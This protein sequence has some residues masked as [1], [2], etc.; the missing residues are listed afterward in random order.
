MLNIGYIS[1]HITMA[2]TVKWRSMITV[3]NSIGNLLST[4]NQLLTTL[5]ARSTQNLRNSNLLQFD[6]F[7][8][9]HSQLHQAGVRNE[10]LW[11]GVWC[12]CS[13]GKLLSNFYQTTCK[14]IRVLTSNRQ[15]IYINFGNIIAWMKW[16]IQY[17]I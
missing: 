3:G 17:Y 13:A 7:L 16:C 2:S 5:I 15:Q 11:V 1:E 9:V 12:H 10:V 14:K 6:N 8:V 4:N